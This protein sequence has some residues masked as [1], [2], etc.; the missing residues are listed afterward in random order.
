[1]ATQYLTCAETAALVRQALKEAFAGVKFSVKSKTYSGGA[2]IT[3]SWTDGPNAVQV[4]SV[5]QG[6]KGSYVDGSIDYKGSVYHMLDG[7]PVSLGADFIFTSR[8]HSAEAIEAA[9]S[10]VL[11]RFAHSFKESGLERPTAEQFQRGKLW[12][13]YL[14]GGIE[15]QKLVSETLHRNS[16]RLKIGKSATAARLFVT[17]DDGYSRACGAGVSAVEGD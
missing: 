14:A 8:N 16:D 1:M 10:R 12:G 5:T 4:E 13:V 9:I 7:Q 2:S 15:L 17:H 3:V 6:F 11:C